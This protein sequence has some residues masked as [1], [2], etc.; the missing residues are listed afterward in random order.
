[1]EM[2]APENSGTH[3][4][5]YKWTLFFAHMNT[6][7]T[8]HDLIANRNTIAKHVLVPGKNVINALQ[9]TDGAKL[10]KCLGKLVFPRKADNV[11]SLNFVR[12]V[13]SAATN[14]NFEM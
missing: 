6:L 11:Q 1:M 14:S 2:K 13:F 3:K 4:K 10:D 12:A 5:M 7:I 9:E 8:C